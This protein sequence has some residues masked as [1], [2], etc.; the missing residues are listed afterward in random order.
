MS[1]IQGALRRLKADRPRSRQS[2]ASLTEQS[3]ERDVVGAFH[4]CALAV[5]DPELLASHRLLPEPAAES[6]ISQQFRHVKRP[7]LR[8]MFESYPILPDDAN[9]V[10]LVS[11]AT[12]GEG[13]SFTSL[14]LAL[15]MAIEPEIQVVLID[16]DTPK[17]CLT[18][19]F[20]LSGQ[21]GLL[22]AAA[23]RNIALSSCIYQTSTPELMFM[24]AGGRRGDSPELLGSSRMQQLLSGISSGAGPCVV[25]MDSPPLLLANEARALASVADHVLLVV[26]AGVT[27][28][29]QVDMA[30]ESSSSAKNVYTMLNQSMSVSSAEYQ[31]GQR[32]GYGTAAEDSATR[33]G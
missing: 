7:L 9:S 6:A 20:D 22:D 30:I 24:P 4:N 29:K 17:Q 2:A 25:I 18:E 15:A 33:G 28:V 19:A 23:D 27:S 11:S 8:R 16:G 1:K 3:P 31:Y 21:A 32:Y 14:H 26:R 13:K 5:A 10:L 12:E